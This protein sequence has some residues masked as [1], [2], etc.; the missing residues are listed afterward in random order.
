SGDTGDTGDTGPCVPGGADVPDVNARDANC[1]GIDGDRRVAIFVSPG[2]T[3]D[4]LTSTAPLGTLAAAL[5][6]ANVITARSQILMAG[7][8]YSGTAAVV[9]RDLII[10][11]GY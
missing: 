1:D 9:T 6:L 3:G 8:D 4:G 7:G 11:G 2:G 5:E 10:A